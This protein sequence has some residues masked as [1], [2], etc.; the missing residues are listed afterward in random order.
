MH[1]D[2]EVVVMA[3]KAEALAEWGRYSYSYMN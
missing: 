1:H 2:G 3:R